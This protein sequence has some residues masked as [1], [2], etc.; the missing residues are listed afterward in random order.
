LDFGFVTVR[1]PDGHVH[2]V[3]LRG[4]SDE[5]IAEV[6]QEARDNG[7]VKSTGEADD[8]RKRLKEYG[9]YIDGDVR[10]EVIQPKG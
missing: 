7:A 2:G 9:Y 10:I 5:A 8:L 1:L 4:S 6:V 3:R